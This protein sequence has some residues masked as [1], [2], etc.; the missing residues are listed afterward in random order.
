MVEV[1]RAK[2]FAADLTLHDLQHVPWPYPPQWFDHLV[3]CGVMHFIPELT[4]IVAEARRLLVAGG[5][6]AFTTRLPASP[7]L[8]HQPYEQ[9]IVGDFEIFSHTPAYV[10][11]LLSHHAFARLKT[12]KCFVGDDQFILWIAAISS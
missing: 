1:C 10:E 7:G 12:Q 9:H 3:C 2:G 5:L 8:H 4:A 11:T 6:F